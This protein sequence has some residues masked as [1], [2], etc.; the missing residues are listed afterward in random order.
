[1]RAPESVLGEH[2]IG[3]AR[4]IAIG[5]EKQLDVRDE[6]IAVRLTVAAA[7]GAGSAPGARAGRGR[8]S[9]YVSHVDIFEAD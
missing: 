5:E 1:M 7:V 2:G 3:V 9:S 4:E 8:L 6:M